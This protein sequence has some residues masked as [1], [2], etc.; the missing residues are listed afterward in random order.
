MLLFCV[1]AEMSK[2]TEILVEFTHHD[3]S[4]CVTVCGRT[5]SCFCIAVRIWVGWGQIMLSIAFR[6]S[7]LFL[8]PL[9][10]RSVASNCL[11]Q[12][13]CYL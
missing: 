4:L 13:A 1:R 8:R 9:Q 11:K 2:G 3:Q 10:V 7:F 6:F 12:Q 5:G